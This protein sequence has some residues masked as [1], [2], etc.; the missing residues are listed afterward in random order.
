[1]SDI[2]GWK[3][4]YKPLLCFFSVRAQYYPNRLREGLKKNGGKG[5]LST[6]GGGGGGGEG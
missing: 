1:M 2:V 4:K 5:D 6:L 3:K